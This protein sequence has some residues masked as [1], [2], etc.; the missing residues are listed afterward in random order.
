MCFSPYKT[1]R[2]P[3]LEPATQNHI[4]ELIQKRGYDTNKLIF[5]EQAAN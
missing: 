5:V 1:S 2:T 4:L 3:Q